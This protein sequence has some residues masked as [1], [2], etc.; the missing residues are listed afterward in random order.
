MLLAPIVSVACSTPSMA[1]ILTLADKIVSL[2]ELG[3]KDIVSSNLELHSKVNEQFVDTLLDNLG[4]DKD[5]ETT[6]NEYNFLKDQMR[7]I[8]LSIINILK[9]ASL[10]TSFI[11]NDPN[12]PINFESLVNE[13][14]ELI[15]KGRNT[16]VNALSEE[17]LSTSETIKLKEN[18][19]VMLDA[20][21]DLNKN[22]QN[23]LDIELDYSK[24]FMKTMFLSADSISTKIDLPEIDYP[25]MIEY[26][27]GLSTSQLGLGDSRYY[28]IVYAPLSSLS[29]DKFEPDDYLN[30]MVAD[31]T[32]FDLMVKN[33]D[34]ELRINKMIH[35]EDVFAPL[36]MLDLG[37]IKAKIGNSATNLPT[38]VPSNR[39]VTGPSADL[40][41]KNNILIGSQEHKL[42][43]NQDD[44]LAFSKLIALLGGISVGTYYAITYEAPYVIEF[45]RE[46]TQLKYGDKNVIKIKNIDKFI[47][48]TVENS[49][50]ILIEAK[51][52]E[53]GLEIISKNIVKNTKVTN[54]EIIIKSKNYANQTINVELVDKYDITF[55]SND[56]Q[57]I[58][59]DKNKFQS[60]K[61]E[62]DYFNLLE[63]FDIKLD[64]V[65]KPG[66]EYDGSISYTDFEYNEDGYFVYQFSSLPPFVD[67][68]ITFI[69]S[70]ANTRS[71]LAHFI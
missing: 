63:N 15:K 28:G 50:P 70:N 46:K 52:V 31:G 22:Q 1:K 35:R 68:K 16:N 9:E 64:S 23:K 37:P 29:N 53:N 24:N 42:A 55:K 8:S 27:D 51:I 36:S 65:S 56:L 57:I 69:A 62:I 38:D 12:K 44:D 25:G 10:N 34:M 45:S 60:I 13:T 33:V 54:I 3:Q 19:N 61:I 47:E 49:A 39:T 66:E 32:Q 5:D 7:V 71:V 41:N 26:Q 43:E 40:V 17:Y 2:Q 20:I 4:I 11:G 6:L 59:F 21:A 14:N 18:L 58:N 48:P 67:T 30:K